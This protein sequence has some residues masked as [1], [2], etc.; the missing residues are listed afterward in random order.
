MNKQSKASVLS[1]A[2]GLAL[3]TS[4]TAHAGSFL[5]VESVPTILGLGVGSGPDYRGSDET[6]TAAAPFGRYTFSGQ[7][8]YIQLQANEVTLNLIDSSKYRLGPVLNYNF[9]RDSSEIDDV[10]VKQMKTIDG[11]LEAGIFGDVV[12]AEQGNPRNR[13][14][15]GATVLKGEEGYQTKIGARWWHQVSPA[16]DLH[17]GGGFL[18][19]DSKYNNHYFGVNADNVG[20]SALPFYTAGSGVNETYLTLG[21]L[22]YLNKEWLLGAGV[23]F[24]NLSGDAGDSPIVKTRGD[25][26]QVIGG[27]AVAYVWK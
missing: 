11:K 6:T 23:R 21:G 13:F 20:T 7:Q 4:F 8:R 19:A 26:S 25:S 10:I 3:A 14:I 5:E 17:V 1:C 15:L 16:V 12:W 9:G 18:Y 22:L 2:I 24:S 27:V